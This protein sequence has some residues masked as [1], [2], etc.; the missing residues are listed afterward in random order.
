M[1]DDRVMCYFA[2]TEWNKLEIRD[3]THSF[4][5]HVTCTLCLSSILGFIPIMADDRV[6]YYF[7]STEWNR[8]GHWWQVICIILQVHSGAD[9][10]IENSLTHTR[11]D[12][13][14]FVCLPRIYSLL[15]YY[16]CMN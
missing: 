4:T 5:F 3:L 1:A 8:L 6:M 13:Y 16:G 12:M 11:R 7:S 10:K 9:R 15:T 2:S 14:T